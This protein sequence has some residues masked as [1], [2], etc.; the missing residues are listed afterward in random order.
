MTDPQPPAEGG[1]PWPGNW[2]DWE[3][4]ASWRAA[5]PNPGVY[6]IRVRDGGR[7]QMITRANGID[8][9]GILYIGSTFGTKPKASRT[10]R[11]RLKE[12]ERCAKNASASGHIA[13]WNYSNRGYYRRFPLAELEY[14]YVETK[15]KPQT[16]N[17]EA[18]L[19]RQYLD[20]FL[21]LPPLNFSVPK[22]ILDESGDT[23]EPREKGH[24]DSPECAETAQGA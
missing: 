3:P 22:V 13:G 17:T 23:E 8:G 15:T 1:F 16:N 4:I 11:G 14:S 9:N 21:D 24:D 19:I 6:R 5:P 12:F 18:A 10:L 2:S 7:C 20:Q